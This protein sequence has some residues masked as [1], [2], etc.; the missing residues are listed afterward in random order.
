MSVRSLTIPV[1]PMRSVKLS[2]TDAVRE[3]SLVTSNIKTDTSGARGESKGRVLILPL[4][5]MKEVMPV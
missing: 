5:D 4:A 2:P 1:R 3:I